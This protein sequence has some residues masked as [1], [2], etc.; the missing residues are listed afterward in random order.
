MKQ[1]NSDIEELYSVVSVT[2]NET[3]AKL[4]VEIF[5]TGLE[6]EERKAIL[7]ELENRDS[8]FKG[9]DAQYM[10][11]YDFTNV[12]GDTLYIGRAVARLI[13]K[14]NLKVKL[15]LYGGEK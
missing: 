4:I 12:T 5:L 15:F 3:E 9:W 6:P 7:E 14:E 13:K 8:R 1:M 10:F 2:D 11:E